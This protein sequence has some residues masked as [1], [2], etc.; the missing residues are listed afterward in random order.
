[1]S[2]TTGHNST[3]G[4]RPLGRTD[5][6]A[7]R[8]LLDTSEFTYTRIGPDEMPRVL[9]TRP[10]VGAFSTPPGPLA[11]ITGGTLQAILLLSTLVPPCAWIG[12]FGVTWAASSAYAEYLDALLPEI[13]R[14]ATARG[15]RTLYYSGNDLDSDWLR[16][17]LE[18]RGFRL[19]TLLR[20][21]DKDGYAIPSWGDTT[22]RVRP[23]ARADT[24]GVLAVEDAAF[25][26]LWRYDA[27][28]F[29]EV[30]DTYP[31]F[32]VAEDDQ[33]IA[34][35]QF[36]IVDRRTGFLVRIA[37][38]PRAEGR[39]VGTRLMAEATYYFERQRAQRIL[40]NTEESN[41]RAHRLYERFGFRHVPPQGFV[42]ARDIALAVSGPAPP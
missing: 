21:Y 24:P 14:L 12:A 42:L 18:A 17:P 41:T 3:A 36:S 38:H 10:A 4:I 27:D 31:Y 2:S 7:V 40:L 6:D 13:E 5:L 34:G 28:G 16:A 8:H 1:M 37:V 25:A 23:F 33:G 39:G 35:Y 15:A 19:F 20:A 32:V 29:A 9:A 26:P 22:L 30:D 11:R